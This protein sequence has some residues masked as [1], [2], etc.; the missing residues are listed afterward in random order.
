MCL[1]KLHGTVKT[2]LKIRKS[3]YELAEP[4][5]QCIKHLYKLFLKSKINTRVE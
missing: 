4:F 5:I 3:I 2:K 1:D